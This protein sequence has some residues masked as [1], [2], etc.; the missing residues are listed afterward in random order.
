M[1]RIALT[2]GIATGKSVCLARFATLGAPTIDADTLARAVVAPGTRGHV[3]V[4]QHFGPGIIA[5]DGSIDRDALGRL[6][7]ADAA[8]RLALEAIIHPEVRRAIDDW[9]DA[10]AADGAALG[11][12][13][14]P[15]L[16][17]TG[18]QVQFDTVVVAACTPERQL[19][20][21]MARSGLSREDALARIA[22]QLPIGDKA[23]RADHVIDTNGAIEE[24]HRQ[25]EA[26]YEAWRPEA[27][28]RRPGAGGRGPE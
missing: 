24:T 12:A 15:L 22:A 27:G 19:A 1:R 10:R 25:V 17:E 14:I 20:R 23:A 5:R 13:D 4:I 28:G 3:A 9:F 11:I 18:R 8:E 21:L 2:G 26:L 7:F 6:V 16:Y